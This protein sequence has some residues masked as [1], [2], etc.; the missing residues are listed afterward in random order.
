MSGYIIQDNKLYFAGIK[1]DFNKFEA[2]YK[3]STN[4]SEQLIVF[5]FSDIIC[6]LYNMPSKESLMDFLRGEEN[7]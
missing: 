2:Y 1:C 5:N 7:D 3:F 4:Y 6:K